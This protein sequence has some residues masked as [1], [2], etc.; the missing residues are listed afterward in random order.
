MM[1][2]AYLPKDKHRIK[3][4]F[5]GKA[6][7][8]YQKDFQCDEQA[9]F[10]SVYNDAKDSLTKHPDT[11]TVSFSFKCLVSSGITHHY[12]MYVVILFEMITFIIIHYFI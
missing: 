1:V 9:D 12:L 3:C 6:E 2:S 11:K 5:G 10:V 4:C 8:C 7:Q